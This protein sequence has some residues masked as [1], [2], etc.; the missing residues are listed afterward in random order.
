MYTFFFKLILHEKFLKNRKVSDIRIRYKYA[1]KIKYVEFNIRDRYDKITLR[2]ISLVS[3]CFILLS[4]F[5]A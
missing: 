3:Y 2:W 5:M 1:S 4:K